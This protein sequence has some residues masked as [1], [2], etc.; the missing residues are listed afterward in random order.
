M[1]IEILGSCWCPTEGTASQATP[2][3]TPIPSSAGLDSRSDLDGG[4]WAARAVVPPRTADRACCFLILN[5]CPGNLFH[6]IR[7]R[8]RT[9]HTISPGGDTHEIWSAYE[10][11]QPI[12]TGDHDWNVEW[13]NASASFYRAT[14]A[15]HHQ[16]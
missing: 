15:G 13:R 14:T 6:K 9:G 8:T 5:R 7:W 16:P 11:N 12:E 2:G 10:M 1:D 3:G 4:F